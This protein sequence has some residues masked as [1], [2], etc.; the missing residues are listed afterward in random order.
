MAL[1][2][3]FITWLFMLIGAASIAQDGYAHGYYITFGFDT[4]QT[5]IKVVNS[6]LG[7]KIGYLNAKG[8]TKKFNADEVTEYGING[9]SSFVSIAPIPKAPKVR[10]FAEVVVDGQAR[11]LYYKLK[12]KYYIKRKNELES[13]KIKKWT[14]RKQMRMFFEDFDDLADEIHNKKLKRHQIRTIVNKYNIWYMEFYIPYLESIE[15]EK[16]R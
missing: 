10:Y 2:S 16:S 3:A 4:V 5:K 8:K 6:I 13:M 9:L 15:R 11:L 14:F 1:R 12:K 7:K